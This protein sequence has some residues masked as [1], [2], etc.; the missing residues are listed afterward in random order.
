MPI[1]RRRRESCRA[2]VG[3]RRE[4]SG[5]LEGGR[6]RGVAGTAASFAGAGLERG[7][8]SFVRLVRRRRE[9]PGSTHPGAR[10][11]E[12]AFSCRGSLLREYVRESPVSTI[13]SCC[14]RGVVDGRA[15]EWVNEP[16]AAAFDWNHSSLLGG[17]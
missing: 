8:D 2:F 6:R 13:A 15:K 7:G 14:R 17:F 12:P 1:P 10:S 4:S 11:E 3:E 5:A 9:L 16:D